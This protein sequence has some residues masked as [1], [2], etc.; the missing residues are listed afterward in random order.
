MNDLIQNPPQNRCNIRGFEY[1][2][3]TA[4]RNSFWTANVFVRESFWFVFI[5]VLSLSSS[6]VSSLFWRGSILNPV[7]QRLI[8]GIFEAF[9]ANPENS[10]HVSCS[11]ANGRVP[12]QYFGIFIT[13][14]GHIDENDHS[15]TCI[16]ASNRMNSP[17]KYGVEREWVCAVNKVYTILDILL[18]ELCQSTNSAHHTNT[19]RHSS[20]LRHSVISFLL[21]IER[22]NNIA[23]STIRLKHV[24][25]AIIVQ[26]GLAFGFDGVLQRII[27]REHAILKMHAFAHAYQSTQ[28]ICTNI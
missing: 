11:C 6:V 14:I 28:M 26:Y 5:H 8:F 25:F 2:Q 18:T 27:H 1:P 22:F 13:N 3:N 9:L 23:A 24:L 12:L 16:D 10:K 4:T 17:S 21:I 7:I 19:R 15:N 20:L